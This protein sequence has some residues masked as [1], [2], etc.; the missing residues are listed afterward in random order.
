MFAATAQFTYMLRQCIS[1]W[2][3]SQFPC[4]HSICINKSSSF[5]FLPVSL[6]VIFSPGLRFLFS[7]SYIIPNGVVDTSCKLGRE[8]RAYSSHLWAFTCYKYGGKNNR[9]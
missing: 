7:R 9:K 6:R 4:V 5:P 1:N 8:G 2:Q 3:V